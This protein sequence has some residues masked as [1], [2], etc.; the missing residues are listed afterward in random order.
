MVNTSHKRMFVDDAFICDLILR[1]CV[2]VDAFCVRVGWFA[3]DLAIYLCACMDVCVRMN[4]SL[5]YM[6]SSLT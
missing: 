1:M 5:R 2:S 3:D 4:V 6:G